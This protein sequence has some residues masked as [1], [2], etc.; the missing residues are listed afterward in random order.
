MFPF[1]YPAYMSSFLVIFYYICSSY[2][3]LRKGT[4][5]IFK[6]KNASMCV[7]HQFLLVS[8]LGTIS[9][10]DA[11]RMQEAQFFL[12]IDDTSKRIVMF[13][14]PDNGFD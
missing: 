13:F 14:R 5:I 8:S 1:R 6:T 12:L 3:F 4:G 2:L 9:S 11:S 7:Y 10:G